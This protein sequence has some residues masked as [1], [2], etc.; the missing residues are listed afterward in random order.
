MPS[1]LFGGR[2]HYSL[3]RPA[4]QVRAACGNCEY[5]RTH[6]AGRSSGNSVLVA[7]WHFG[8]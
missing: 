2:A 1:I 6:S 5:D 7:A 3:K 4:S 8:L